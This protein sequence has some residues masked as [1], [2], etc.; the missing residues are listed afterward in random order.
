MTK[1]RSALV[2]KL[3]GRPHRRFCHLGVAPASGTGPPRGGPHARVRSELQRE[4]ENGWRQWPLPRV[5]SPRK[6]MG[7][8]LSHCQ[9]LGDGGGGHPLVPE[10]PDPQIQS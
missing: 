3:Q 7:L 8:V 6:P 9:G 1:L 10:V 4:A 5:E 2:K